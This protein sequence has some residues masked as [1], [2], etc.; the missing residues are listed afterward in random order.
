[1]RTPLAILVAGLLLVAG[2]GGG[3]D[4][5]QQTPQERLEEAVEGHEKAVNDQDCEAFARFAHSAVRPPGK[6][7]DDAPDAEE[8]SNLGNSYT[9]LFGFRPRRSKV[10]GTAAIVEGTVEG[11]PL[12]L[13]W[14]LDEG[15]WTQ[16]QALPGIDPQING[17]PRPENSFAANAAAFVDA[18]RK[19]DCPRVFRLLN[20]GS[21]FVVQAQ[22]DE[23]R[24]CRRYRESRR[25]PERLAT[26]LADAP[27][28]TRTLDLGGTR[29]LHFFGLDTGAGRRWTLIMSTPPRELPQGR[30]VEDSVLDYYPNTR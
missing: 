22:D 21:P 18:Q 10:Y 11:R 19:G 23:G 7:P 25:A 4:D 29:D 30:P 5:E 20:P 3:G 6:G 27:A 9:R 12:V 28:A 2:C 8:C 26:Q 14:T 15:R 16:V 24:F 1:M 17:P 13:V